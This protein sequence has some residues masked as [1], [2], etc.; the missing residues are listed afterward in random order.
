MMGE[1][2]NLEEI[3]DLQVGR[4]EVIFSLYPAFPQEG[5]V[6]YVTTRVFTKYVVMVKQGVLESSMNDSFS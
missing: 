6:S 4:F 1:K 2:E 5:R 3:G